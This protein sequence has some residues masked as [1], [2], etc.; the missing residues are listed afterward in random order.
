[1]SGDY[2]IE[3]GIVLPQR[4]KYPFQQMSVGDSFAFQRAIRNAVSSAAYVYARRNGCKFSIR[5][6]KDSYRCFRLE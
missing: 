6:E 1:M 4:G 3:Q 5:R 2:V